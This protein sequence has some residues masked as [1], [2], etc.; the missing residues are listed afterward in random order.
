MKYVREFLGKKE[1]ELIVC[2]VI[3]PVTGY[4]LFFLCERTHRFSY[5]LNVLIGFRRYRLV[6][7]DCTAALQLE[8][9]YVKVLQRR[10]A[11]RR[12][13][14]QLEDALKD[15]NAALILEPDNTALQADLALV[16]QKL[17]ASTSPKPKTTQVI[18][19]SDQERSQVIFLTIFSALCY[20]CL[21]PL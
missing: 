15:L 13:L 14:N 16:K 4:F 7:A 21:K 3:Q 1:I 19:I 10:A 20:H 18:S 9:D 17:T 8:P 2:L 11:A 6:E 12:E 5:F